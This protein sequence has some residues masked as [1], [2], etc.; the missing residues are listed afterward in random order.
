[1]KNVEYAKNEEYED[2]K[3]ESISHNF[4]VDADGCVDV[5]V[6]GNPLYG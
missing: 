6:R 1:M 3:Y 2:I 4:L 5:G